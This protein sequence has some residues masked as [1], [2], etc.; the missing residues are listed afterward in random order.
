LQH[1]QVRHRQQQLGRRQLHLSMPFVEGETPLLGAVRRAV[2][3]L[4]VCGRR[5]KK[6]CLAVWRR[7]KK[8]GCLAVRLFQRRKKGCLA[9]RLF[10]RR[11]AVC[12]ELSISRSVCQELAS[13]NDP[14]N[15]N[16]SC[17]YKAFLRSGY[18]V[19][20]CTYNCN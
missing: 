17:I 4:A 5:K 8:K 14:K 12:E 9:V 3:W 6:G 10:Q 7:R 1:Q 20:S 11:R 13:D 16:Y 2:Y 19:V 18:S 15:R